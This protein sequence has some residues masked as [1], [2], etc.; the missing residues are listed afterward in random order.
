MP[1]PNTFPPL[2]GKPSADKARAGAC[3]AAYA[4]GD[5]AEE[6]EAPRDEAAA[7]DDAGEISWHKSCTRGKL[8]CLRA[9]PSI[10]L[11]LS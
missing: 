9:K 7:G 3:D 11:Y 10:K 5:E 4:W 6:V 8:L 1:P 2:S